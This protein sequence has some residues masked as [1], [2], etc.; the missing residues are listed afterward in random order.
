[1]FLFERLKGKRPLAGY[2]GYWVVLTYL[3]VGLSFFGMF[4]A[5][6][7]ND[8][9]THAIVC[10]MLAGVCDTF[11]G[12]VA[13][14]KKRDTRQKN[15]GIQIDAMADLI[16]FGVFPAVIG[17]ALWLNND[18]TFGWFGAVIAAVFALAA[19]I[20]LAHFNVNELES[21]SKNECRKSFEGLPSTTAALIIPLV[22]SVCNI[23]VYNGINAPF[24]FVYGITLIVIAMLFVLR[25]PFPKPRGKTMIIMWIIGAPV[26]IGLLIYGVTL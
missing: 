11:D 10:L 2:Y 19:L 18:N 24:Y 12:K 8:Y 25:F 13:S 22:F 4:F 16:S 14:T 15:Y 3:S 1:M 23:L 26:T 6:R 9:I 5:L 7:G 20:R 17:L 21:Q